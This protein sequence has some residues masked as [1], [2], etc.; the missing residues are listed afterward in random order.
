MRNLL[1]SFAIAA[2][3]LLVG[4][5]GAAVHASDTAHPPLDVLY[6]SERARCG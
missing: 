1:R 6:P 2:M 3:L 5:L 4:S